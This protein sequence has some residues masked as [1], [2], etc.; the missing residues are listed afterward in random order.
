MARN[1]NRSGLPIAAQ[2]EMMDRDRAAQA[3]R[4]LP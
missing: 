1:A 3:A 4:L 2:V